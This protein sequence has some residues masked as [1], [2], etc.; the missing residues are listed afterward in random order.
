MMYAVI[1]SGGKQYRVAPGDTVQVE[2]MDGKVG[3]KV[4]FDEVLTVRT[5][6]PKTLSGKDVSSAKVTGKILKH[7]RGPKVTVMKYKSCNQYKITRGHRQNYT[8]I[9]IGEIAL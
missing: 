8:A 2:R 6:D 9:E 3:A 1:K 4:T 5:D 7:T